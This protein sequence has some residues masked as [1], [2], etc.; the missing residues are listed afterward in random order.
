LRTYQF[1]AGVDRGLV[2]EREE[3]IYEDEDEDDD[4]SL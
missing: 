2:E 1:Y 3:D 4:I